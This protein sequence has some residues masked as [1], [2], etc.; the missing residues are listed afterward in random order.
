MEGWNIYNI[1]VVLGTGRLTI[2]LYWANFVLG[3]VRE[4]E[5]REFSEEKK[6]IVGIRIPLIPLTDQ[7]NYH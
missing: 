4:V 1:W 2:A 7:C 3:E 5:V 6:D